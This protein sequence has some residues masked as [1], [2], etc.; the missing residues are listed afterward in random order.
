MIDFNSKNVFFFNESSPHQIDVFGESSTAKFPSQTQPSVVTR[1]VD[2]NVPCLNMRKNGILKIKTFSWLIHPGFTNANAF[3]V[4]FEATKTT[5]TVD[6][7]DTLNTFPRIYQIIF[8][9]CNNFE[10]IQGF[11][12]VC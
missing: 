2:R 8:F 3:I 6:N 5:Q 11:A 1:E 7:N 9:F 4:A 12:T 10:I